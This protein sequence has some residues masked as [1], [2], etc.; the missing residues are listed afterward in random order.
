MRKASRV[1]RWSAWVLLF[2]IQHLFGQAGDE[3][4]WFLL[5]PA[6]G[7]YSGVAGSG[8]ALPWENPMAFIYNPAAQQK[9]DS[10]FFSA[11]FTRN[12]WQPYTHKTFSQ[13][14][15]SCETAFR[16]SPSFP[17]ETSARAGYSRLNLGTNSWAASS[18]Q[19]I[20]YDAHEDVKAIGLSI[21]WTKGIFVSAGANVKNL[22]SDIG[23]ENLGGKASSW[24]YDYGFFASIPVY[25][26]AGFAELYINAHLGIAW[27]N[28]GPDL[29]YSETLSEE[30]MARSQNGGWSLEGG[31]YIPLQSFRIEM[32]RLLWTTQYQSHPY[33][34][35]SDA[36]GETQLKQGAPYFLDAFLFG[37]T[38]PGVDIR[39][40]YLFTVFEMIK[41]AEGHFRREGKKGESSYGLGVSFRP[42]FR[43]LTGI[44]LNWAWLRKLKMLNVEIWNTEISVNVDYEKIKKNKTTTVL[45]S[46]DL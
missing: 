40:G 42:V 45:I 24:L 30:I 8:V 32:V 2:L 26:F 17:F 14:A 28:N 29:K 10:V 19:T 1:F 12:H 4:R 20:D 41:I 37:L 44:E 11:A 31:L 7:V 27:L 33:Y 21:A 23:P 36:L 6:S 22:Q 46:V 38:S 34:E 25:K 43:L 9:T 13:T 39:S 18:G 16:L 35:Y 5:Y 3:D 15:F